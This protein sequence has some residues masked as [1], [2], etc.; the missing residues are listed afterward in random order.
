MRAYFDSN[1]LVSYFLGQHQ[2]SLINGLLKKSAS[3]AFVIVT[4]DVVF[5]EIEQ[6]CGE[7]ARMLRQDFIDEFKALGKLSIVKRDAQ[8]LEEAL[9]LNEKTNARYGLNDFTHVLLAK[10]H[11]DLF[12]TN[13]LKFKKMASEHIQTRDAG[14]FSRLLQP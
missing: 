3:C 1:L 8:A 13:D 7:R 14:E 10:K 2:E 4:S 12:V 9:A 11:A 5:A 6:V